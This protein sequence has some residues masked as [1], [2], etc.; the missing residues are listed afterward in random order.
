LVLSSATPSPIEFE[1]GHNCPNPFTDNTTIYYSL[2]EGGWV[3]IKIYNI[4]GQ[5]VIALVDE[6]RVT[7]FYTV[8]WDGSDAYDLPV[9]AGIYF[10]KICVLSDDKLVFAKTR[11]ILILR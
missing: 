6:K 8:S 7:G 4:M 11:K 3:S 9:P 5:E 1:L 10:A 2:P